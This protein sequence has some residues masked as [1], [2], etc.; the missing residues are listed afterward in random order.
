MIELSKVSKSYFSKTVLD[1]VSL[2]LEGSKTHAFLGSSGSGKSTLLRIILGL[3]NPDSGTIRIASHASRPSP[4]TFGYVI[5]EGGLFPHLTARDN[6]S[7]VAR[8]LG[9][10]SKR[11]EARVLELLNLVG[12]EKSL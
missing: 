4:Q 1:S 12:L 11:T 3:I 5:Q 8:T 2:N 10:E 6:V 7:L 9:W